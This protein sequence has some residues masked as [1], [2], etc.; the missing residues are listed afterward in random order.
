[1]SDVF[2]CLQTSN[3]YPYEH[4]YFYIYSYR[5]NNFVTWFT[6]HQKANL[7]LFFYNYYF[8]TRVKTD[9]PLCVYLLYWWTLAFYMYLYLIIITIHITFFPYF[10]FPKIEILRVTLLSQRTQI[11]LKHTA[12]VYTIFQ[13]QKY[14]T[15]ELVS[16]VLCKH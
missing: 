15:T 9:V 5:V 4:M 7:F 2:I 16:S 12:N 14:C 13:C 11:F 6:L 10:L 8:Y 1:M 3:S